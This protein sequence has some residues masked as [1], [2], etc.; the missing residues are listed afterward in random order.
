MRQAPNKVN[1]LRRGMKAE[2]QGIHFRKSK[3]A[4]WPNT[5]RKGKVAI[6]KARET[7]WT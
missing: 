1:S 7:E 6:C 3:A 5:D 4:V 2:K